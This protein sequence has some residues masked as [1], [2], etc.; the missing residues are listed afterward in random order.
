[1]KKVLF[2][3]AFNIKSGGGR[4]ILSYTLD[5]FK[6]SDYEVFILISNSLEDV[7]SKR[8]ECFNFLKLPFFLENNFFRYFLLSIIVPLYVK[9][10]KAIKVLSLGNY[11]IKTKVRQLTYI[12]WP[13]LVYRSNDWT[14]MSSIGRLK[15]QFKVFILKH[16][17]KKFETDFI[18][19]S[20]VMRSRL[21]KII[22]KKK[23][24]VLF[25]D[26][27]FPNTNNSKNNKN[28]DREK[29]IF[30]YPALFYP[31]KN[32]S[33]IIDVACTLRDKGLNFKFIVTLQD[34]QFKRSFQAKIKYRKLENYIEDIGIVSSNEIYKN[35]EKSNFLFMPTHL[36][37]FGIPY[38]EAMS[39]A[40]PIITSDKDFSRNICDEAAIYFDVSST[41]D[42]SEKIIFAIKNEKELIT[43]SV[44]RYKKIQKEFNNSN[45][46]KAIIDMY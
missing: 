15:T 12:H 25:P 36:E 7:F 14:N 23:C 31:H 27:G 33:C 5:D 42:I 37:T 34:C 13:Y 10:T 18:V 1:M 30:F 43:K 8:Y 32:H 11:P 29:I 44:Q 20:E 9:R 6:E 26:V 38:I 41:K 40:K 21:K 46:L 22:G 19:Q 17:I 28:I 3:N 16:L 2:I 24:F 4:Q 45:K 35:F 39:L